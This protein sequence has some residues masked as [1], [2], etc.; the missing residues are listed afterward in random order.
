MSGRLFVTDPEAEH[1]RQTGKVIV[2]HRPEHRVPV[3][4]PHA[5]KT[6]TLVAL[7][8]LSGLLVFFVADARHWLRKRGL[9]WR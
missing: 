2:Q 7:L 9:V 4:Q 6:L 1:A 8:A 5:F 3:R